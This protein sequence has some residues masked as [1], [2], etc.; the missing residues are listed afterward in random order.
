MTSEE[1]HNAMA[2][3]IDGW[4]ERRSLSLLRVLLPVY[5]LASG[6]T[7]DW[8]AL[9]FSLKEIR[10]R[11]SEALAPGELDRVISL[12]HHAEGIVHR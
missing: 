1:F 10:V 5:P 2:S 8:A 7:D 12:L 3:L 6:L 9:A 4:C 11:H